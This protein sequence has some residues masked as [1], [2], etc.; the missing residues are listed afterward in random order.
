MAGV[1]T[2]VGVLARGLATLPLM[3][4]PGASNGQ[5]QGWKNPK[6]SPGSALLLCVQWQC[7]VGRSHWG[8]LVRGRWSSACPVLSYPRLFVNV[9]TVL[10]CIAFMKYISFLMYIIKSFSVC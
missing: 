6:R 7:I 10:L 2:G 5:R 9:C 8:K 4:H 1:G 3:V